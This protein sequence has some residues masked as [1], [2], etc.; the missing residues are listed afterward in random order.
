MAQGKQQGQAVGEGWGA[1]RGTGGGQQSPVPGL[2]AQPL[3]QAPHQHLHLWP[4]QHLGQV[5]GQSRVGCPSAGGTP[6][7]GDLGWGVEDWK[8]K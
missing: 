1:A 2:L 6:G 3:L 4:P 5:R 8:M 7:P